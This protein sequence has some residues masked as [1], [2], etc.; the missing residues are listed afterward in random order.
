[1]K[2]KTIEKMKSEKGD[3][4]LS[5]V[6]TVISL[7]VYFYL[8]GYAD[9]KIVFLYE[10]LGLTPFDSMTTGRYWM[11]GF[12]LSGFLTFLYLIAQFIKL[13]L[14]KSA[15]FSWKTIIK[16]T[17]IPLSVGVIILTMTF[18]EPKMP[19][20]IA[21][22]CAFALIIGL[23]IGFSFVDDL[24]TDVKSTFIYL[25]FSL[26]LIPLLLLFRVLELP[27]KGIIDLKIAVIVVLISVVGGFCWL[28]IF[29]RI[30]K[31][32]TPQVKNVIKGTLLIGYSGLPVIH[33]LF[34]TPTGIPYI[35]SSDNFFADSV[36]LRLVNWVILILTVL[37][38]DKF[39]KKNI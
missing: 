29:Y 10:H 39:A 32:N 25:I 19:F 11:T 13:F 24:M 37:L 22:S 3:I 23:M 8:F 14:V 9:R 27:E 21:L 2:N 5:F 6:I 30:F 18:G 20:K 15:N 7:S 35:T 33:Y 26:G 31:K 12:V 1:M 16:F 34:A 28:L 38:A 4:L 36:I 17:W